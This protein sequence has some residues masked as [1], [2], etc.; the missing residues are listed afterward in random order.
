MQNQNYKG[1]EIFYNE[2]KKLFFTKVI[3]GKG[4]FSSK[5]MVTVKLLIKRSLVE[6]DKK[7]PSAVKRAWIRGARADSKYK[8]VEVVWHDI[9]QNTVT[10]RNSLGKI[11]TIAMSNYK[12]N[13]HKLF[14]SNKKNDKMVETLEKMQ[15]EIDLMKRKKRYAS[16]NLVP[17]NNGK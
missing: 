14:F 8:L 4:M 13:N 17:Y 10:I 1:V 16:I 3:L 5:K 2:E 11:T 12:Y 15:T 9:K 7:N 6:L